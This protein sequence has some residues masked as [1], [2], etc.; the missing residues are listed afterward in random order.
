M[1]D[2]K[3]EPADI[4]I[5]IRDRGLALREKSLIAYNDAD[6]KI[7]AVGTEAE[8]QRRAGVVVQ[9]PLRQGMV[10]DYMAAQQMFRWMLERAWGKR[11]FLKPRILVGIPHNSTEVERKAL[12]DLMIQLG[13]KGVAFFE[14]DFDACKRAAK[15]CAPKRQDEFQVMIFITKYE[16]DRYVLE[17]LSYIRQYAQQQGLSKERIAELRREK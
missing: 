3:Y 6:G 12:E 14:G 13:A 5:Y 4:E 2:T 1:T 9:S 11:H 17:E 8:Q 16:P 7:L 15:E 10:A